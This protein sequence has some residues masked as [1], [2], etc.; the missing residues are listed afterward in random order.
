MMRNIWQILVGVVLAVGAGI[1]LY[2][3]VGDDGPTG[4]A[5]ATSSPFAAR[6]GSATATDA[7]SPELARVAP[8]APD[9]RFGD[10]AV[11]AD[12]FI[13][14]QASAPVTIVEYASLTC[15]HCARFHDQVLPGLKRDLI[16]TGKVRLVYRDFPL[17]Q[18]A[19]AGSVLARC[20]GRDRYFAFLDVL[21]R[22]Q[23]SWARAQDPVQAL[24]Q[25]ARLGGIGA[26]K[27]QSC[28]SDEKLQERILKQRL[29]GNQKL[30]VNS[31]PTLFINGDKYP[32]VL[33][34]DQI[35]AIVANMISKS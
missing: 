14:G 34:L 10:I 4:A 9:A 11:A 3:A 26:E 25:I 35:K 7:A 8:P 15:P 17:D 5:D 31:T 21:Y 24:S 30:Q 22:D 20:A 29:D 1:A 13:I 32:G 19:L 27:F 2:N 33:T 18:A 23:S 28:L 16:D 6:I 12:D